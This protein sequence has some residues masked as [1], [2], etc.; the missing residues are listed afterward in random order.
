MCAKR[1]YPLSMVDEDKELR[2]AFSQAS[3][4]RSVSRIA[5]D[6]SIHRQRLYDF[7]AK[8]MLGRAT[9]RALRQ[10]LVEHG[11]INEPQKSQ[12]VASFSDAVA[13]ELFALAQLLQ[14]PD[15]PR[16]LKAE[17]FVSLIRSYAAGIDAYAQSIA[18]GPTEPKPQP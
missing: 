15:A 6:L 7:A 17:R 12:P 9:R 18:G 8:D 16:T 4:E 5:A 2:D 10:W 14:S 13:A 1:R 11:Y 3:R